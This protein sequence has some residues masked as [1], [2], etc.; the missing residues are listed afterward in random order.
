MSDDGHLEFNAIVTQRMEVAP[1]LI[2][3]DVAP[4]GWALPDFGPGQYAVIGLP[5]SAP[6]FRDAEP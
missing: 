6:R 4:D 3:M 5:G 2:V 1:G